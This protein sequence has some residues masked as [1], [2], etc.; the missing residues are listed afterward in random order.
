MSQQFLGRYTINGFNHDG[1]CI[2][3][4]TV[5]VKSSVTIWFIILYPWAQMRVRPSCY[6]YCFDRRGFYRPKC[7]YKLC[8]VFHVD[9]ERWTVSIH[10]VVLMLFRR[11]HLNVNVQLLLFCWWKRC[12]VLLKTRGLGQLQSQLRNGTSI[13]TMC[14]GGARSACSQLHLFHAQGRNLIWVIIHHREEI[15][16]IPRALPFPDS[17]FFLGWQ[18]RNGLMHISWFQLLSV[19]CKRLL[20]NSWRL[21]HLALRLSWETFM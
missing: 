7:F 3:Q 11:Y 15:P 12:W 6:D 14:Y 17:R 5:D 4:I 16:A 2:R 9:W 1:I 8:E 10:H 20:L 18:L 13:I 19:R 21:A